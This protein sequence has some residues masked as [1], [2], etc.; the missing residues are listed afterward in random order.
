KLDYNYAILREV[1]LEGVYLAVARLYPLSWHQPVD[2][3]H[4]NVL[5]MGS[6]EDADHP[7]CRHCLVNAPQEIMRQL[8]RRWFLKAGRDRS[9]RVYRAKDPSNNAVLAA[10]IRTLQ[11]DQKRVLGLRVEDFL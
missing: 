10:R 8:V 1:L 9:E 3:R 5:I 11:N 7:R 4:Q 6:V 2:A